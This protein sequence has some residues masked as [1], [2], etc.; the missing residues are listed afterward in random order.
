MQW[1]RL[2]PGHGHRHRL[3]LARP[4]RLTVEDEMPRPVY[5][6]RAAPQPVQG[7]V[8]GRLGE[9]QRKRTEVSRAIGASG[10]TLVERRHHSEQIGD[11]LP[12][13]AAQQLGLARVAG[14]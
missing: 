1:R 4:L 8:V 7:A 9:P 12:C 3:L 5:A 11:R 14:L 6:E 2:H 10:A 13:P